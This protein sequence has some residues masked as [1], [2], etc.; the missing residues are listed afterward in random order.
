MIWTFTWKILRSMWRYAHRTAQA[1]GM[2]PY[3]LYRQEEYDRKSGEHWLCQGRQGWTLQYTHH[4]GEAVDR[5]AWGR[6]SLPKCV[7]DHG[8]TVTRCENV[9]DVGLYIERIEEMIERKRELFSER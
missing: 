1:L 3:Y 6:S 5:G 7:S 9:K 2:G 8:L 4:G